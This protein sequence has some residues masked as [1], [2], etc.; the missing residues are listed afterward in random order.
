MP[1]GEA[2]K[3]ETCTT[4][5]GLLGTYTWTVREVKDADII[6][7]YNLFMELVVGI[8]IG[9]VI[10]IVLITRRW[11]KARNAQQ[12]DHT[13]KKYGSSAK[14]MGEELITAILPTINNDV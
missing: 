11:R 9:I 14:K 12:Q 8:C 13:T 4:L 10:V 6:F 2:V 3:V 7:G 5:T 1:H